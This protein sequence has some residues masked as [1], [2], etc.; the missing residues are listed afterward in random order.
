[1]GMVFFFLLS[2]GAGAGRGQLGGSF[3]GLLDPQGG[4]TMVLRLRVCP[5][6]WMPQKG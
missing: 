4:H 1:V 5:S 6:Y 3:V 2:R